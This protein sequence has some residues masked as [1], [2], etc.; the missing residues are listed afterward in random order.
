MVSASKISDML[1]EWICSQTA[2]DFVKL[3]T[4]YKGTM[5]IQE[6]KELPTNKSFAKTDFD[7]KVIKE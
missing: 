1:M 4:G 5:N 6:S 3:K 7:A 2:H